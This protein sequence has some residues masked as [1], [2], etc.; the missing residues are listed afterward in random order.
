MRKL[1]LALLLLLAA[2]AGCH[3]H[4][5]LTPG[6]D[7]LPPGEDIA[8]YNDGRMQPTGSPAQAVLSGHISFTGFVLAT[9]ALPGGTG[10]GIKALAHLVDDEDDILSAPLDPGGNFTLAYSGPQSDLKLKITAETTEDLAGD[11]T[12]GDT[13]VQTVPVKLQAG[14]TA[15][16]EM[17][18]M[19]G[20]KAM[21]DATLWPQKGAAVVNDMIRQ[22]GNGRGN[23]FFGTYVADGF[24]VISTDGD[25]FLSAK[26]L[27]QP[28]AN[29][30]GW[31][32]ASEALYTDP[33]L[34]PASVAG[35]VRSVSVVNRTLLVDNRYGV[36][37][38]V[39]LQPF[40]AL[41]LLGTA[42][43]FGAALPL[44]ESL[45]GRSVM[46]TGR[47]APEGL[48]ADWVVVAPAS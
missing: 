40:A 41:E 17:A 28:D 2:A 48:L 34:V 20:T 5:G 30:D 23:I 21:M 3:G 14:F 12:T 32:D 18:I 9:G 24:V 6:G 27:R 19:R 16:V 7:Q 13:I 29:C 22:D 31:P 26:D 42:G 43:Y 11:G 33:G 25:K 39:Y 47:L 46:A 45:I 44:N 36:T 8:N 35:V 15:S 1:A 37:I 4:H 10:T 38:L